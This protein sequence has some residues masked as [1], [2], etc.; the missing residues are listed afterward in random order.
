MQRLEN[1]IA[2]I[3]RELG[4]R[5]ELFL[6]TILADPEINAIEENLHLEM[7]EFRRTEIADL[8]DTTATR[9]SVRYEPK[10][11]N[12]GAFVVH[13]YDI[14]IEKSENVI[15]ILLEHRLTA[16]TPLSPISKVTGMVDVEGIRPHIPYALR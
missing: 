11:T 9:F 12:Y 6:N 4:D 15:T 10:I 7:D 3:K 5:V 14:P 16:L 8:L 13:F 2:G 1:F